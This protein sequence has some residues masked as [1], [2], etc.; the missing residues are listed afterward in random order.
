ML[1]RIWSVSYTHLDVYK[2]QL[3]CGSTSE[4]IYLELDQ[5][6]RVFQLG[7]ECV[8]EEKVLI[9]GAG[10]ANEHQV[11]ERLEYLADIGYTYSIICP[12]YYYP[13]KP[14]DIY[15]FYRNISCLLYTSTARR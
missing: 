10:G 11:M 8:S 12:P 7:K 5:A 9:G 1:S 15:D 4:F 13:Q 14:E 2:R 6:K 3:L